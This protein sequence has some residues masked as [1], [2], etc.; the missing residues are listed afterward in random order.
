M[1]VD[2]VQK[3]IIEKN[4]AEIIK[5]VEQGRI[6]YKNGNVKRGG[7]QELLKEIYE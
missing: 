7:V 2:I 6:D 5:E 1:I 4:R 3:R